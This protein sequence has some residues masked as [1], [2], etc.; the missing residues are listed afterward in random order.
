MV[1]FGEVGRVVSF[2]FRCISANNLNAHKAFNFCLIEE[3]INLT[4]WHYSVLKMSFLIHV[5][6]TRTAVESFQE[7]SLGLK[8]IELV[9]RTVLAASYC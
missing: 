6:P 3:P 1:Y 7:G 2:Q 9:E 5:N 4:K 8:R